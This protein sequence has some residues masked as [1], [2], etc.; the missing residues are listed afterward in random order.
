MATVRLY[1]S[2]CC[3]WEREKPRD[4][5]IAK[6]VPSDMRTSASTHS[7]ETLSCCHH[8]LWV[9]GVTYHMNQG[10]DVKR[11]GPKPLPGLMQKRALSSVKETP[12]PRVQQPPRV[13]ISSGLPST[14]MNMAAECKMPT[15]TQH[16]R[17]SNGLD[18]VILP[19]RHH[20]PPLPLLVIHLNQ[21]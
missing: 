2:S 8:R 13:N 10:G 17:A 1:A 9:S 6:K 11:I 4:S 21:P 19:A 5:W 7:Q 14:H 18:I 20:S 12:G 3:C 16:Q 15:V